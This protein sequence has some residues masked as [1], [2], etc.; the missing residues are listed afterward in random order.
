MR[1]YYGFVITDD[2]LKKYRFR[3]D[4]PTSLY[5]S[6]SVFI[7]VYRG[8]RKIEEVSFWLRK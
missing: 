1:K 7:R 6:K 2:D 3:I 5:D 8:T 4:A